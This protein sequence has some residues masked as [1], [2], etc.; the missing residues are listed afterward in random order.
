MDDADRA[1]VIT[2]QYQADMLAKAQLNNTTG[3]V[4]SNRFCENCEEQIPEKRR[5]AVPGCKHC[6]SCQQEQEN[7]LSNWRAI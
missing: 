2:E 4:V 6:V 1:L 3:S 7:I 5:K